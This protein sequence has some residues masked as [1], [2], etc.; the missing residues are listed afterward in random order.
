MILLTMHR[1]EN[2]GDSMKNA[3]RAILK[4]VNEAPDLYLVYPIHLNPA[5]REAA[6]EVLKIILE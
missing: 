3:F 1:R 6:Y 4:V 5:V 2:L